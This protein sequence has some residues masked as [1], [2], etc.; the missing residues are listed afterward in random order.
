MR[1]NGRIDAGLPVWHKRRTELEQNSYQFLNAFRC[2][3][4]PERAA[5]LCADLKAA[6][7]QQGLAGLS[8][9]VLN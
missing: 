7:Q 4:I 1:A 2:E 5:D 8:V 6:R 9:V 3:A